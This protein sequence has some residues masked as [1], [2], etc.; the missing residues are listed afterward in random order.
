MREERYTVMTYIMGDYEKVHEVVQRSPRARYLLI[1]DREDLRSDTWEVIYDKTLLGGAVNKTR[2]VKWHPW[3]YTDDEVVVMIDGSIGVNGPLDEVIDAFQGHDLCMMIHP[4]RN[5]VKEEME[6]WMQWRGLDPNDAE[7]QLSLMEQS[8][9]NI[10][11]YRGLYQCCFRMMRRTP[12]VRWYLDAVVGALLLCGK[13]GDYATPEQVLASY[14]LNKLFCTL[15]VLWVS[16]RLVNSKYL[17]W[18]F[19]NSDI[20][21]VHRDL[22]PFYAFNKPVNV[23]I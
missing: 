20:R 7:R 13:N 16:E 22:I 18:Y 14:V 23:W 6:A 4:E 21:F 19:H 11:S 15:P 9:Y 12:Q 8:G 10:N 2:Y 3:D 1:T 5:T 17:A